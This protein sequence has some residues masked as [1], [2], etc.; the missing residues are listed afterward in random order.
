MGKKA[1]V[2][3]IIGIVL[4]AGLAAGGTF[5][6]LKN[7]AIKPEPENVVQEYDKTSGKRLTLE[8]FTV[9]LVQTSSQSS[10]IAA[11]FT[12]IFK[13]EDA[14]TKAQ[15]LVPDIKE[16]FYKILAVKTAD[17]LKVRLVSNEDGTSTMVNPILDLKKDLLEAVKDIYTT[18]ED[19]ETV[20]DVIVEPLTIK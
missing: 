12:I 15:D 3:I 17:Q 4:G 19:K 9:P 8:K 1:I 7:G 2:F 5:F 16:A 11:N 14:L 6:M 20:I 13:D 10:Y 18:E